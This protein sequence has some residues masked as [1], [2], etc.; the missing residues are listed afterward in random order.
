MCDL[1]LLLCT[2]W[3]WL[4][5]HVS[6]CLSPR[7]RWKPAWLCSL[8]PWRSPLW[9]G[10]S[11]TCS[12]PNSWLLSP[13]KSTAWVT[14]T[15]FVSATL[16]PCSYFSTN[17]PC[18]LWSTSSVLRWPV[19][20]PAASESSG[21][22]EGGGSVWQQWHAQLLLWKCFT[23]KVQRSET[24]SIYNYSNNE[25]HM[26]SFIPCNCYIHWVL[27]RAVAKLKMFAVCSVNAKSACKFWL[28][29]SKPAVI[30][31]L[32][33]LSHLYIYR[34]TALIIL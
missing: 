29:G 20:N 14:Y 8:R 6:R 27:N 15:W 30:Y 31:K 3:L 24:P 13:E 28:A 23:W 21:R 7:R 19:G 5:L 32:I 12:S 34:E 18:V 11:Q 2:R 26:Y 22:E 9:T 33:P 4:C 17:W 10:P 16:H 25:C 1:K